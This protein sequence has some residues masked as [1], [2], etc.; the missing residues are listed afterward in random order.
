M[1]RIKATALWK[2]LC[3]YICSYS[4]LCINFGNA[5][6]KVMHFVHIC[7][8]ANDNYSCA[9]RHLSNFP[10]TL[11]IW[12]ALVTKH[13]CMPTKGDKGDT[14]LAVVQF[15]RETCFNSKKRRDS[16]CKGEWVYM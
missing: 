9:I 8:K 4:I 13:V 7:P 1:F 6:I 10:L 3:G 15:T 16:L 12:V 11:W 14:T 2:I 5:E